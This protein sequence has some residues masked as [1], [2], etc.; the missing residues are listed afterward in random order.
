MGFF[1]SLLSV[2]LFIYFGL[3]V[4]LR[5]YAYSHQ[6]AFLYNKESI[7]AIAV[8]L[9]LLVGMG[10]FSFMSFIPFHVV[11][12]WGFAGGGILAFSQA[13]MSAKKRLLFQGLLCFSSILALYQ[14]SETAFI[15]SLLLAFLWWMMWRVIVWFDQFPFTSLLVSLGWTMALLATGLLIHTIPNS[16]VA[17]V[18]LLGTITFLFGY[19]RAA[20]KQPVWGSLISSL[21]GF[22]WAGIWAYFL[23]LGAIS[24]TLTAFGYYLF[25]FVFLIFAFLYHK[26]LQTFL[27]K[28]LMNPQYASKAIGFVFSHI[29]LLSFFAAVMIHKG[30]IPLLLFA[31]VIVLLDLYVRL[32]ALENPLPTW[33]ELL[34]NT[35]E[36]TVEFINQIK[37][38]RFDKKNVSYQKRPQKKPTKKAVISKKRLSKSTPKKKSIQKRKS[39]K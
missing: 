31:L 8:Y 9:A 13:K 22:A 24:Q 7:E 15:F 5:S 21:L 14:V 35:R 32:N 28:S 29:L 6:K 18:A 33:R 17:I 38:I 11:A 2:C 3:W 39:K 4:G 20:Q 1:I 10:F 34:K 30:N 26:P 36:G 25:E 16:I 27:A 23:N 19:V 12:F 37:R